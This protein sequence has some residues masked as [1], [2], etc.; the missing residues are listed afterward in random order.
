MIVE[1][2]IK[3]LATA[4]RFDVCGSDSRVQTADLPPTVIYKAA[5]P[6]GGC[7]SLFKVL[8]TN[9]CINDCAYCMCAASRDVKRTSFKPE[10]LARTFIEFNRRRLATGLFLSSGIGAS[11]DC[12]M[13]GII[14]TI[15]I[16][17]RQYQFKGY[18]HAKM[19]P[20]A[21]TDRIEAACRLAS[22]VSINVEAPTQERLNRLSDKKNLLEGIYVP[23][24]Q[25]NELRNKYPYFLPAGQTTQFVVG[26]AG[27]SDAEVLDT[28]VNLYKEVNLR[29]IYFSAYRPVGDPRLEGVGAASPWRQHRLYQADWLLRV[30]GFPH[31]EVSLALNKWGNLPLKVNP[32]FSIA[33]AQPWLF[34]VDI[35]RATYD[36]LLHVPGIG[37]RSA[38][39]ITEMRKIHEVTSIAQLKQLH[40]RYRE[41]MPFIWFN[42]MLDFEKQLCFLPELTNMDRDSLVISA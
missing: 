18:I 38:R 33:L 13:E 7:A 5:L 17:R 36:E 29:R 4:A 19:L 42:G 2:K 14:K 21:S 28:S 27:E 40:V 12:A 15:E 3:A 30:Y 35:N 11:P 32:K 1:D 31:A 24:R 10:E 20:G 9:S 16:L 25:A 6:D 23:M 26:A 39:R 34:P 41:A 37:P 22:R 8:L